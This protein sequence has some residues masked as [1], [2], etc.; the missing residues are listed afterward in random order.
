MK[1]ST[2]AILLPGIISLALLA[3]F[4]FLG[5]SNNND[6]NVISS[7]II[8][9]I[10]G[11]VNSILLFANT[12]VCIVFSNIEIKNAITT[13]FNNNAI[14]GGNSNNNSKV[15]IGLAV[16]LS[17]IA[18]ISGTGSSLW[19]LQ[20]VI[21]MC[22]S[23]TVARALQFNRLPTIILALFGLVFYDFVSVIGLQQFTDG[24]T[25]IMEAVARSKFET[26]QSS[27]AS[28][29]TSIQSTITAINN[30]Q[31]GLFEIVVDRKVSDVLGL[32]DIVFPSILVGWAYRFDK[33][34][35]DSKNISLFSTSLFGYLFGCFLL[36]IFQTGSGQP[37]LIF[38]VP[39]MLST[40][41]IA[42]LYNKKLQIMWNY[43]NDN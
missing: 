23:I 27:V 12:I 34:I 31:P 19:P 9:L 13:L 22:I 5:F 41:F 30:W 28:S 39:S 33:A 26:V 38:L 16:L 11:N 4:T 37:A 14:D 7:D 42:G 6:N 10:R 24:G 43:K 17:I 29:A 8:N 2:Q 3:S 35:N 32:A 36:E 25:S 15:A 21:N 40:I 18:V 1:D 20:N